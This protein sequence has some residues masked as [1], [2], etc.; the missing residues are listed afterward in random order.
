MSSLKTGVISAFWRSSGKA[1]FHTIYLA[2]ILHGNG[3]HISCASLG[4]F[5]VIFLN[6]PSFELS[7]FFIS[8]LILFGITSEKLHSVGSLK[9]SFV[10]NILGW[11][12]YLFKAMS[13]GSESLLTWVPEVLWHLKFSLLYWRS[14]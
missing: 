3:L 10:L 14:Y 9:Y 13:I 1:P 8:V 7:K 2:Y 12:T 11:A 6:V 5:G 4:D